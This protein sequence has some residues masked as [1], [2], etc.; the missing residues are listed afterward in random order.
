MFNS[1]WKGN[2]LCVLLVEVIL[3]LLI[4]HLQRCCN[5]ILRWSRHRIQ[6][7]P[8]LPASI[9]NLR[10]VNY[11]LWLQVFLK[12][13]LTINLFLLF[14]LCLILGFDFCFI[15]SSIVTIIH[16]RVDAF[17]TTIR[18][19][20]QWKHVRLL[21]KCMTTSTNYVLTS[22]LLLIIIC[23]NSR[24]LRHLNVWKGI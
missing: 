17:T 11:E 10:L 14:S 23:Y 19:L 18:H 12:K 21:L 24:H 15:E 8:W 6:H 4:N 9:I 3:T 2:L 22:L 1:F 20:S 7:L 5:I 13:I 16:S